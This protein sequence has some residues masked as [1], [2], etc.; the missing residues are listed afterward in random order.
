MRLLCCSVPGR[1]HCE[2][3]RRSQRVDMENGEIIW[4]T[5][6][7]TCNSHF[8]IVNNSIICGY[9]F[10]GEPDNLFVLDKY[11]GQR[12]QKIPVKKMVNEVVPKDGLAYVRTY[13]FDY[14]FKIQ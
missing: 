9:G 6:P 2:R 4:T 12:V 11:S 5:Q 10:T 3:V 13:S 14:V 8:A 1:G 7:M